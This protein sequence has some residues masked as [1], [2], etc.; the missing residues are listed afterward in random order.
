ME[1]FILTIV[2]FIVLKFAYSLIFE[3]VKFDKNGKYR[4]WNLG[5]CVPHRSLFKKSCI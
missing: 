5:I 3:Q 2:A 1:T 4:N